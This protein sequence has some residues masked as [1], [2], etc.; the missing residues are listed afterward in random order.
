[1][2]TRAAIDSLYSVLKAIGGEGGIT[3]RSAPRPF[4]AALT[5]VI[6]ASSLP[7]SADPCR[8]K[9]TYQ[10]A[11]REGFEPSNTFWDVTHFPG[12]RLR[13]LGHLSKIS[14]FSNRR[15]GLTRAFQALALRARCAR[16]K[17]LPRF[18]RTL[19]HLLGCYSLSRRAPSTTRPPLHAAARVPEATHAIK[20][21]ARTAAAAQPRA[22]GPWVS[23]RGC[24][25]RARRNA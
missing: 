6:P 22:R 14:N 8:Q 4:G 25:R 24:P 2:Q 18:C 13:P 7:P 10:L 1:M 9:F 12:E 23:A 11:E 21:T 19:E 16:P 5:G 3:R 20:S 17:S 15:E